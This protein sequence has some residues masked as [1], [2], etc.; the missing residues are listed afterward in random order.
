MF[1][2]LAVFWRNSEITEVEGSNT[3]SSAHKDSYGSWLEH[4]FF[5]SIFLHGIYTTRLYRALLSQ[6]GNSLNKMAFRKPGRKT[7]ILD[8]NNIMRKIK[9]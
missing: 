5:V 1:P 7:R 8:E 6:D 2:I 3:L 4:C 9:I